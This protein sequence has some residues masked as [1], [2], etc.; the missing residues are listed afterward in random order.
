MAQVISVA[1]SQNAPSKPSWQAIE[2]FLCVKRQP[3]D[4]YATGVASPPT[5][6]G[7]AHGPPH[8][9]TASPPSAHPETGARVR[10]LFGIA[11]ALWA[12]NGIRVH[13][14]KMPWSAGPVLCSGKGS[15]EIRV[16]VS[17]KQARL[18]TS[19]SIFPNSDHMPFTPATP[20][21]GSLTC[22][23]TRLV[24]LALVVHWSP[25]LHRRGSCGIEYLQVCSKVH[26]KI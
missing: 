20:T 7:T 22:S 17:K 8:P 18:C 15:W 26:V 9:P 4:H 14:P 11:P 24:G 23:G 13:K 25:T 5:A 19:G 3:C 1:T 6:T 2:Q 16:M 12:P 21:E 10:G